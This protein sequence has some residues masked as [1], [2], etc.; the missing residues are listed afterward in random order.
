MALGQCALQTCIGISLLDFSNRGKRDIQR[1]AGVLVCVAFDE[2]A[3]DACPRDHASV[4]E[5]K[6]VLLFVFNEG[7]SAGGY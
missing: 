5:P 7:E 2:F 4:D 6:E 3:Q 1:L